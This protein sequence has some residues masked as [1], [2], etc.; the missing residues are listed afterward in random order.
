MLIE[1]NYFVSKENSKCK[2]DHAVILLD[3]T[4]VISNHKN[5]LYYPSQIHIL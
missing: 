4:K 2:K 1:C 3:E 5:S